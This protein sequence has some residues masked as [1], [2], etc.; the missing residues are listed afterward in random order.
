[1][2]VGAD[3]SREC[4]KLASERVEHFGL[5]DKAPSFLHLPGGSLEPIRNKKFDVIWAQSVL[6]HLPE[7]LIEQFFDLAKRD[8]CLKPKIFFLINSQY[9]QLLQLLKTPRACNLALKTSLTVHSICRLWLRH[10]V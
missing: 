8:F 10:M 1:M 7:T 4:L 3:V 5:G 9:L 6:T 2:Y